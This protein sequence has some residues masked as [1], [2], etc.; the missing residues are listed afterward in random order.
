VL[1][2]VDG[3]TVRLARRRCRVGHDLSFADRSSART[4]NRPP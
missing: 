3:G 2:L 1:I 4:A